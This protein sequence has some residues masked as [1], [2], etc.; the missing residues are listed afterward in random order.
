MKQIIFRG[1]TVDKLYQKIGLVL[2]GMIL[3]MFSLYVASTT[4][5]NFSLSRDKEEVVIKAENDNGTFATDI[6]NNYSQSVVSVVNL[7][8]MSIRDF[9]GNVY[10]SDEKVQQGVGSGF[11]YKKEDGY[12]YAI[13]NNHVVADSDEINIVLNTNDVNEENVNE[14]VLDASI[15]GVSKTYD[16]AVI[17]FKSKKELTPVE[18]GQSDN[19][20]PGQ[21]VVAIGSPY[22]TDFQGTITKGIVSSTNRVVSDE[23]GNQLNYIQTDAAINPG[24]SGG[25]LFDADGHVIGMNTMKISD[26]QSDNM[27]FAIPIDKVMEIVHKIEENE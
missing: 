25:P 27:G 3:G 12:Y 22:G 17:K 7:R 24:N 18:L 26:M 5:F 8:Q 9:F 21:S 1:E 23:E 13:T 16:V 15:V 2:F 10:T 11:I 14:N 19:L 20:L 6:Y 4:D